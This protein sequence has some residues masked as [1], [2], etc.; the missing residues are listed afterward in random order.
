[1]VERAWRLFRAAGLATGLTWAL[2]AV[3][4]ALQATPVQATECWSGWGYWVEPGTH[5]YKSDRILLVTKGSA[6]WMQG[7]PVTFYLLD[8]TKGGIRP[9]A[10]PIKA[11]PGM[12]RFSQKQRLQHVTGLAAVEG[13]S[14][15]LA[16]GMSHIVQLVKGIEKLDS[17]YRW[18]CGLE[19][20]QP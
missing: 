18:A 19:T 2:G 1:M 11:L 3:S 5:V 8:E 20:A 16:F 6:V 10:A 14:D 12:L 17:F 13:K 9:D 4:L 15:H 7:Q